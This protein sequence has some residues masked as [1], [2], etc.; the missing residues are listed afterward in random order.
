MYLEK[1]RRLG[2]KKINR[3]ESVRS[4]L[5]EISLSQKGES[6]K[7]YLEQWRKS[8]LEKGRKS[9]L[10][11]GRKSYLEKGRSSEKH[12]KTSDDLSS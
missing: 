12:L 9:Y 6:W 11:K 7:S 4:W 8:Y 10:E 1:G 5:V 3:Q 2:F